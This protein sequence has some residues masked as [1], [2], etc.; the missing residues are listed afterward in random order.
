MSL[1]YI[2]IYIREKREE[3]KKESTSQKYLGRNLL[4]MK[5]VTIFGKNSSSR[6]RLDNASPKTT[7]SIIVLNSTQ[8]DEIFSHHWRKM[9][10]DNVEITTKKW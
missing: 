2:Y 9:I 4:K 6:K 8:K 7:F 5:K 1:W 10:V 3:E